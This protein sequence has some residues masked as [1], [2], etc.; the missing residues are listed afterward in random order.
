MPAMDWKDVPAFYKTLSKA[1]TLTQ[2]A[3]RLLILTGVRTRPLRHIHKDQIDGD[4]WI[5]LAENNERK[6]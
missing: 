4:I 6:A 1:S 2:L 3:L 5:I